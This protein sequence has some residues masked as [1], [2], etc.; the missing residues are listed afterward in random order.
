MIL[1]AHAIPTLSPVVGHF[2]GAP[3]GFRMG[4]NGLL[5]NLF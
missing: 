5:Q 3:M 4:L 2:D 1:G